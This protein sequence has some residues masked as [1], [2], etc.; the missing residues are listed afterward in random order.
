MKK[1]AV[2]SIVFFI[3]IL[4]LALALEGA[5]WV[6]YGETAAGEHFYDKAGIQRQSQDVLKVWEETILSG[7]EKQRIIEYGNSTQPG[8]QWQDVQRERRLTAID[9]DGREQA[10]L[11]V[12]F[13]DSAMGVVS[14]ESI[15]AEAGAW[16]PISFS[17]VAELLYMAVC[18]KKDE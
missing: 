9:C 10:L 17:S 15:R 2:T 13:Y 1:I 12:I 18:P 4:G 5:E 8:I 11:A 14:S 3:F 7:Q 6:K 16:K